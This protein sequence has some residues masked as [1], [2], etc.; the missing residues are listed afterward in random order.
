MWRFFGFII[1][2]SIFISDSLVAS[3]PMPG[4]HRRKAGYQ[5]TAEW[6]AVER[7]CRFSASACGA[8]PTNTEDNCV[9]KC[10]SPLCFK[11]V[12]G[13]PEGNFGEGLEPGEINGILEGKFSKCLRLLEK[14]LRKEKRWP[15]KLDQGASFFNDAP[16]S[17]ENIDSSL[18]E[19]NKEM[20][21]E[22]SEE[23]VDETKE[24]K[25]Q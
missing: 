25:K 8:L 12:Y 21:N 6:R 3:L 5:A 18:D 17:L 11:K 9:L 14:R 1:L 2:F 23:E 4:P 15:P 22:A 10:E 24:E 7:S 13:G 16:L 19:L 20:E